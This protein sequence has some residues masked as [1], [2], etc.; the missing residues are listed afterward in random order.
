MPI[1]PIETVHTKKRGDNAEGFHCI[2]LVFADRLTVD[3]DIPAVIAGT[4]FR[5]GILDRTEHHIG[6]RVAVAMRKKLPV[7]FVTESDFSV[8]VLD[9][10]GRIATI[11][12]RQAVRRNKVRL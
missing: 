3:H 11:T 5:T 2:Q 4:E 1:A 7:L 12:E 6:R 9:M 8:G 10:H